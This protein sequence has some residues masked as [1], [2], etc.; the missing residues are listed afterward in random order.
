MAGRRP[1]F[2]ASATCREAPPAL[3]WF[4]ERGESLE[5]AKAVCAGCPVRAGCLE[6]AL[7][8]GADLIGV[9]GG[10][11]PG[12]RALLRSGKTITKALR[13]VSGSKLEPE[14]RSQIGSLNL[15][16][17]RVLPARRRATQIDPR[18]A[19]AVE[20][21]EAGKTVPHIARRYGVKRATVTRWLEAG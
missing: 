4:P 15:G 3:S 20:L 19:R 1:G 17:V 10:T 21:A 2:W 13:A 7:A 11:S 12:E 8:Q 14:T 6:W 18:A 9:W 16:E 5:P